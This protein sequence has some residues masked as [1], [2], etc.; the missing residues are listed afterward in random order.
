MN[1]SCAVTWRDEMRKLGI[2]VV[3]ALAF[4][5]PL[6]AAS[7]Q[8]LPKEKQ[9]KSA[10]Y[11]TPKD[12]YSVV[13]TDRSKVLFVDIRTRGEMQFVG[14]PTDI[15]G[16]VP[17]VEMNEFGEW[18]D[19]AGRYK[20][21]I[22]GTFSASIDKL[23]AKKGLTKDARIILSCRSGD[24]SA[25]AADIMAGNGYTNVFTQVE[26]FE[27]DLSPDGRRTVNGW[28]NAGLPWSYKLDKSKMYVPGQ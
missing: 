24:R 21:E 13:T 16:H 1:I 18:D 28:K 27:G 11:L 20:L 8:A 12:A 6:A 15:D 4:V 22:N 25:R 7:A 17:F 19:K 3:A 10:K 2:A 14:A 23:L 9:T 26:G 5:L